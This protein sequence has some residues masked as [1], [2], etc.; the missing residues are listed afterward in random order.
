MTCCLLWPRLPACLPALI[1]FFVFESKIF[2]NGFVSNDCNLQGIFK[3]LSLSSHSI[4]NLETSLDLG[5]SPL[6][7]DEPWLTSVWQVGWAWPLKCH[8]ALIQIVSSHQFKEIKRIYFKPPS[9]PA[10]SPILFSSFFVILNLKNVCLLSAEIKH[11]HSLSLS[12]F[13]FSLFF[14]MNINNNP[15]FHAS[16]STTFLNKVKNVLQW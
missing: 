14:A 3:L 6:L 13:Q 2:F 11:T 10:P 12:F 8:Q 5:H 15:F 16:N 9:S 4:V 1:V 7:G